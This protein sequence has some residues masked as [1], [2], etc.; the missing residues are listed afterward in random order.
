CKQKIA[1]NFKN[2]PNNFGVFAEIHIF[3]VGTQSGGIFCQCQYGEDS[4]TVSSSVFYIP[5][6]W[7]AEQVRV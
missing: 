7:S 5:V 3:A 2:T 6:S 4:G 1:K